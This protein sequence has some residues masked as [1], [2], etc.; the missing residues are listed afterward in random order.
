MT[1]EEFIAKNIRDKIPDIEQGAIDAAIQH[2]KRRQSEKKAGMFDECLK[3]AKQH[4][5]KV[6][7]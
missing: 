1:P 6:K 7:K 2:Y 3:I 4:M 5:V